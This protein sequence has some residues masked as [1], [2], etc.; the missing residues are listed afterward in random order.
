MLIRYKEYVGA[1]IYACQITGSKFNFK[2][3]DIDNVIISFTAD[4]SEIKIVNCIRN[5]AILSEV[6]KIGGNKNEI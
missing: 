3:K 2:I 1:L 4:M 6:I 5:S